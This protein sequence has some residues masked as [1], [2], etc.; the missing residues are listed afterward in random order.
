M[1][2]PTPHDTFFCAA[3]ADPRHAASLIRSAL[4]RDPAHAALIPH[5]AWD[6]LRRVEA[7]VVDAADRRFRVDLLF[8]AMFVAADGTE[9][10]I[11]FT[12]I[13]E[14]KRFLDRLT[15]WQS[16]RYQVRTIDWHRDQ[17]G[18]HNSWP[19]VITIVV[20]HGD[21]PW[22]APRDMRELFAL[23]DSLPR[24][25]R[26]AIRGLLPSSRY[27]LHDLRDCSEVYGDD[28]Q[29]SLVAFLAVQALKDMPR[30]DMERLHGWLQRHQRILARILA[31]PRDRAFY[32][33][34]I[35]YLMNTTKVEPE[36]LKQ[37][38]YTVLPDNDHEEWLSPF[39]RMLREQRA[40]GLAEGRAEG[41]ARGKADGSKSALAAA[42]L[43][44]LTV[45]FGP[46]PDATRSLIHAAE[47]NQLQAWFA[48]AIHATSMDEALVE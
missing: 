20:Y 3:F 21:V 18:R 47:T 31:T 40:E 28:T 44:L 29:L 24:E 13:F 26:H 22:T 46:I 23:P 19:I 17:P 9:I 32:G 10:P 38:L 41:E 25:L 8:E 33:A 14:H 16:L 7:T 36:V 48:K 43:Q 45:R 6:R 1:T 11:L 2:D 5:I 4:A 42:L 37:T 39:Q 27:L 15:A 30:A 35:W 12:P 34:L